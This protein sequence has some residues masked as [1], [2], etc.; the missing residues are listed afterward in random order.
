MMKKISDEIKNLMVKLREDGKTIS[1]IADTTKVSESSVGRILRENN[2]KSPDSINEKAIQKFSKGINLN[3]PQ[4]ELFFNLN[5]VAKQC[6]SN[7]GE[8]LQKVE[9]NY[10]ELLKVTNKPHEIYLFLMDL[11]LVVFSMN[12]YKPEVV[13]KIIK[14]VDRG[15]FLSNI[16][17]KIQIKEKELEEIKSN[18]KGYIQAY[19]QKKIQLNAELVDIAQKIQFANFIHSGNKNPN[20]VSSEDMEKVVSVLLQNTT[21][22]GVE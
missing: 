19:H 22:S 9:Y 7:I 2:V 13:N 5:R 6:G 17:S 16:E 12:F 3:D 15:L 8:F 14:L 21:E 11:C 10:N 18:I 1:E 4:L 20:S